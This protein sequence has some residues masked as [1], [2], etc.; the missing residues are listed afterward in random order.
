MN[1]IRGACLL[2]AASVLMMTAPPAK[3]GISAGWVNQ[4]SQLVNSFSV[5]ASVGWPYE[6][7]DA[8]FWGLNADYTRTFSTNWS[9]SASLTYDQETS[10]Q[11]GRPTKVVNS[12][13]AVLLVNFALSPRWSLSTGLSQ[14]FLDDDNM[15]GELQFKLGD[16][17]TGLAVGVSLPNSVGLSLAWEWN[18][19]ESEPSVS[20]D[21]SYSWE[22]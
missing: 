8:K 11:T 20:V 2:S 17:G 7:E 15:D 14:D 13:A 12:F 4:D 19:S 6:K 10:R 1:A 22:F 21:I 5:G 16:V 3:A 18:I 9:A